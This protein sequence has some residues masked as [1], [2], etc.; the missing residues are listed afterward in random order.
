MFVQILS[1]DEHPELDFDPLDATKLWPKEQIPFRHIGKIVLNKNPDNYFAETEQVAFGTGVLVDGLDF[2]DDKLL[3]GRTFSYSDTQ[4]YR[5][6]TNYLQLPINRPRVPV[7]TNQ[8]DGQ[9]TYN[10]DVASGQN[11]H[12]NYEPSSM[13]GLKESRPL[14]TPYMPQY[15]G[16][17]T[18]QKI[19]RDNFFKQAGDV[20]RNDFDDA[21]R[22]ECV[23]N[24]AGN[25]AICVPDVQE[26]IIDHCTKADPD[27]GRRVR[28][29]LNEKLKTM[30]D[31]MPAKQDQAVAEA[32]NDALAGKEY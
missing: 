22:E 17:L 31:T 18:R 23:N 6:G 12:I 29:R 7:Y 15:E 5:V 25:L 24:I 3:V 2:S 27:Y 14:G 28:E 13:N 21:Y 1:D 10:V 32:K 30:K 16:R 26:K 20:W 19:D 9:M 11:S 8:R 4:R